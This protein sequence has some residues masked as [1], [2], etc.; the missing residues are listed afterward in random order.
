V[1]L[2]DSPEARAISF[3]SDLSLWLPSVSAYEV[4]SYDGEG[5]QLAT[6]KGAGAHAA[7]VTRELPAAGLALFEIQAE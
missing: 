5:K 7:F 3:S 4:K 2:N 6:W 1:A